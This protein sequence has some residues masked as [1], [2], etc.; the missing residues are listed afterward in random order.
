MLR[1]FTDHNLHLYGRLVREA[2]EAIAAGAFSAFAGAW[3]EA[4]IG[5]V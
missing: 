5:A 2:R 3:S 1:L 4:G